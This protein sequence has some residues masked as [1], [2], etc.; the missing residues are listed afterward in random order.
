MLKGAVAGTSPTGPWM[1]GEPGF[2]PPTTTSATH[3]AYH[4]TVH[5][6]YAIWCK[7]SFK[8]NMT[9][10]QGG[11]GCSTHGLKSI[12]LC[13]MQRCCVVCEGAV[14][15]APLL[16]SLAVMTICW[17]LYS[18]VQCEGGWGGLIHKGIGKAGMYTCYN[19]K[20]IFLLTVHVDTVHGTS[21]RRPCFRKPCTM[22]CQ[23]SVGWEA[24]EQ[25][26][27]FTCAEVPI[28][29]CRAVFNLHARPAFRSLSE[30]P[31]ANHANAQNQ[32][33]N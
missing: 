5:A 32:H 30:A 18:P 16:E 9:L 8:P 11:G 27:N 31:T 23:Q 7:K 15:P 2:E 20:H 29:T 3:G 4:Y 25:S 6:S 13:P 10:P 14:G 33:G 24:Q 1:D 22:R 28:T 26:I 21:Q 12:G 17:S 19:E